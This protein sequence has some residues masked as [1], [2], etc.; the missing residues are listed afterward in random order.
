MEASF[1]TPVTPELNR[2]RPVWVTEQITVLG[3][4]NSLQQRNS[5]KNSD[6]SL[7]QYPVFSRQ[8][9]KDHELNIFLRHS[10]FEASLFE[11]LSPSK[12][13]KSQTS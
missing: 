13:V 2:G 1:D 11:L 7:Y 12:K 8:R 3:C 5:A 10:E 9:Q 4:H 6:T